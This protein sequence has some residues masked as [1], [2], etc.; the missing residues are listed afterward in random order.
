MG[1]AHLRPTRS[2]SGLSEPGRGAA[3]LKA[4]ASNLP[5]ER[6]PVPPGAARGT[7]VCERQ[8]ATPR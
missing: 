2:S 7:G 4:G 6:S 1:K 5:R 8:R 3:F